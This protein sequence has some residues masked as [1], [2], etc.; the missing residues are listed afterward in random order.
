MNLRLILSACA[1]ALVACKGDNKTAL[2]KELHVGDK[3][4]IGSY[5]AG[6]NDRAMY[7]LSIDEAGQ[8]SCSSNCSVSWPP[9]I[10]DTIPTEVDARI[11]RSKLGLASRNDGTFQL[12]F[13]RKPLYFATA[14]FKPGDTWG[15]NAMSYGGRFSLIAPDGTPI[16]PPR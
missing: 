7:V 4:G 8:A 1:I 13:N 14:D 15:H 6:P 16:P 10:V 3:P 5:V 9:V 11:D 2:V 12:V